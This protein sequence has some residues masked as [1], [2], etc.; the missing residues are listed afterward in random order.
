MVSTVSSQSVEEESAANW[1]TFTLRYTFNP[2]ELA[3][4][5]EFD[6]DELVVTDPGSGD[7]GAWLSAGRGSYVDIKD[8]R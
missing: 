5:A 4:P 8:A 1:P 7:D 2:E 3:A 6:P